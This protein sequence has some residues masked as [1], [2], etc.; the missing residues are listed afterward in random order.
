MNFKHF[1]ISSI[2]VFIREMQVNSNHLPIRLAEVLQYSYPSVSTKDWF[3]DCLQTSKSRHTQ[4]LKYVLWN[5]PIWKV[6]PLYP[7]V[8]HPINSVSFTCFLVDMEPKDTSNY[9]YWKTSMYKWTLIVPNH[10]VWRSALYSFLLRLWGNMHSHI[11]LM[12]MQT[13]QTL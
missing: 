11:L 9:I 12:R 7:W 2:S 13:M 10:L 8:S 4:S 3:Q 5:L 6:G 1:K